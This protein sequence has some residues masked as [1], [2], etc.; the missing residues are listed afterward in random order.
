MKECVCSWKNPLQPTLN[1][2]MPHVIPVNLLILVVVAEG[3]GSCV[4][5]EKAICI[6]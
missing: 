3:T 1:T 4:L 5:N 6:L 2:P